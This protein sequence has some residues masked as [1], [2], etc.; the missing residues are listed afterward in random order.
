MTRQRMTDRSYINQ[1]MK[2][3]NL[4]RKQSKYV[5]IEGRDFLIKEVSASLLIDCLE[6]MRDLN[7]LKL[8]VSLSILPEEVTFLVE[9]EERF[10]LFIKSFFD[11][12]LREEE[13]EDMEEEEKPKKL[14]EEDRAK[15]YNDFID[16][17]NYL[18]INIATKFSEPL[19]LF[20]TYSVEQLKYMASKLWDKNFNHNQYKKNYQK[21]VD[22]F[23]VVI[24]SWEEEGGE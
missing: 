18:V 17:I 8:F 12:N 7:K 22:K 2:V 19:S 9:K 23:G 3:L 13:K 11:L 24:E 14:T 6:A 10:N 1:F 16:S 21:K 15:Y 5:S 20:N 4:C